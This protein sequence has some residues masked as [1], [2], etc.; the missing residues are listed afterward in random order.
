MSGPS[1]TEARKTIQKAKSEWQRFVEWCVQNH[2]RVNIDSLV[3]WR[4]ASMTNDGNL[5]LTG[6]Q[7]PRVEG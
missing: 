5:R 7:L 2:R 4:K 3:T 6:P 1:T